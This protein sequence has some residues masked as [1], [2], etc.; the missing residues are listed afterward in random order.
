[1]RPYII[2]T[3]LVLAIFISSAL[4]V[5]V[6]SSEEKI[7]LKITETGTIDFRIEPDIDDLFIVS[8][9]GE[10]PW[11]SVPTHI[12]VQ[13]GVTKTFS[14]TIAP[15]PTTMASTYKIILVLESAT[16]GKKYKVP[17]TLIVRSTNVAIEHVSIEN[18]AP[19]SEA[20]V[21]IY[22]RNYET[23]ETPL[24]VTYEISGNGVL[25]LKKSTDLIL[26]SNEF[27]IIEDSFSVPECFP[28]GSYN[29]DIRMY[30]RG[31]EVYNVIDTWEVP[32]K[33][34]I[35]RE[36][37]DGITGFATQKGFL[38]RNVGNV[39]GTARVTDNVWGSLFFSGDEP[40]STENGKYNWE[41]EVDACQ[42][43][44]VGYAVNYSPVAGIVFIVFGFWLVFFRLRSVH[45]RKAVL[46]KEI[47]RKGAEYTVGV[48]VKSFAKAKDIVVKDFVPP[49]FDVKLA[50][51]SMQPEINQKDGGTE[52]VWRLSDLKSNEERVLAY[53]LVPLFSVT[54]K[55]R[56]PRAHVSFRHLGRNM[57]RFSPI[58][59]LGEEVAQAAEEVEENLF[60]NIGRIMK[61]GK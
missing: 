58:A 48:H 23:E 39:P 15:L 27:R 30:Y 57:S 4:A 54:G 19:A 50:H 8:I 32:E 52:L 41:V 20:S 10:Q 34:V 49:A 3:L 14:M 22:M 36:E 12:E 53:K 47:I 7:S 59:H 28:A 35:T 6:Y 13:K 25:L 60:Q 2:A 5:D 24:T 55:I 31:V 21:K 51:S 18:T 44:F 29:I 1:M 26:T 56:L 46:Q 43:A 61:F 40:T 11:I 45:I 16:T 9:K 33:V 17:L 37:S 38:V 42:S